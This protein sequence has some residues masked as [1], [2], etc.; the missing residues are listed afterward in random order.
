MLRRV[1]TAQR[2]MI[3]NQSVRFFMIHNKPK[4]TA[5]VSGQSITGMMSALTLAKNDYNVSIYEQRNSYTRNIQWAG[6]QSLLDELA[7]V[8][9][10]LYK[11]FISEVAQPLEN[12][13]IHISADGNRKISMRE[14]VKIA[15]P[16][17][18]PKTGEEMIAE[19]SIITMEAKRFEAMLKRFLC[20]IPNIRQYTGSIEFLGQDKDRNHIILNH[21][22]P[23]LIVIAEGANSKT[24]DK[25]GIE[26]VPTSL[27][28]LQI[29]GVL[30]LDSGGKMIKHWRNESGEVRL[31]GTMGTKNSGKT[32]IV[33]DIDHEKITPD[34]KYTFDPQILKNKKKRIN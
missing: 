5:V 15:D 8:D 20:T 14:E 31:T 1:F 11:Q 4:K 27:S 2:K 25:L 26:S 9:E 28:K 22:T 32:W 24:R 29:A 7:S 34:Q 33:A 21:N 12:G 6:R 17:R 18:I 30:Y 19:K 13:S 23:D 16:S 3:Q 10:K